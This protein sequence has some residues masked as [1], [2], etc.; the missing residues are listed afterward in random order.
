MKKKGKLRFSIGW[1]KGEDL[2]VFKLSIFE[3]VQDYPVDRGFLFV[4]LFNLQIV[5]FCIELFIDY[6]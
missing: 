4:A 2:R 5:K 1:F 3:T 6:S